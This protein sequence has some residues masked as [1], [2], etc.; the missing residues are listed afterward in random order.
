M[1]SVFV[2]VVIYRF[3]LLIL[4]FSGRFLEDDDPEGNDGRPQIEKDLEKNRQRHPGV[5]SA[6][7]GVEIVASPPQMPA[8][9]GQCV[10]GTEEFAQRRLVNVSPASGLVVC[11]DICAA[12]FAPV[13]A[14]NPIWA[15]VARTR[16]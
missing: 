16:V 9:S 5:G 15:I 10:N 14:G 1:M 11:C 8:M 12:R 7:V 3:L 6:S 4:N 13:S 2:S